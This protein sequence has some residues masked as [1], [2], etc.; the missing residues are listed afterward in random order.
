MQR[1]QT[2]QFFDRRANGDPLISVNPTA[3]VLDQGVLEDLDAEQWHRRVRISL[4]I[5][6][7]EI[8]VA[9][10]GLE[11]GSVSFRR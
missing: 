2:P 1:Q 3:A 5:N 4:P 11:K 6:T 10:R 8:P 9:N 7:S